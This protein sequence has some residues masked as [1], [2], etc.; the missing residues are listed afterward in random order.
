MNKPSAIR[1]N[2]AGSKKVRIAYIQVIVHFRDTNKQIN[3]VNSQ[4]I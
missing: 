3:F 4:H 1:L 2:L